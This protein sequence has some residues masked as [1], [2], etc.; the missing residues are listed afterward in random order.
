V[1]KRSEREKTTQIEQLLP[2]P[3]RSG[4]QAILR[5][6]K[7]LRHDVLRRT[8]LQIELLVPRRSLAFP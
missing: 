6:S 2:N 5:S 8:P 1:V 3:L 7:Q 4:V